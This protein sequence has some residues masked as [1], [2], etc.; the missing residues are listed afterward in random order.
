M[1]YSPSKPN[2][3]GEIFACV[4][5]P[6]PLPLGLRA[7]IVVLSELFGVPLLLVEASSLPAAT[8]PF[9]RAHHPNVTKK[10]SS[11]ALNVSTRGVRC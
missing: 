1:E 9:A 5:A 7:E 4:P 6:E 2:T 11:L 10:L 8:N 3:N